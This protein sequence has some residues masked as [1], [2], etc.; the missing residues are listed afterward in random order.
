MPWAAARMARRVIAGFM[1]FQFG[2]LENNSV[3][4]ISPG[5]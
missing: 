2:V 3:V 5:R 1:T 4:P